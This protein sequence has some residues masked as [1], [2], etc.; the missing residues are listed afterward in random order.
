VVDQ[1]E[2]HVTF[3]MVEVVVA[4][5]EVTVIV[6]NA[7]EDRIDVII[8]EVMGHHKIGTVNFLIVIGVVEPDVLYVPRVA[9]R[10]GVYNVLVVEIV[11]YVV[12]VGALK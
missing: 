10:I 11:L 4:S 9:D 7:M 1:I 2:Y 3:V 8:V 6:L 12:G 5:V